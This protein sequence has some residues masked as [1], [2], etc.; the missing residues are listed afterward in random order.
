MEKS[1]AQSKEAEPPDTG[2]GVGFPGPLVSE[3]TPW[4]FSYLLSVLS[5]RRGPSGSKAEESGA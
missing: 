1:G 4:D 3:A 5:R 2:P